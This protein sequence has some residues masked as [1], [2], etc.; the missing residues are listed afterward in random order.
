MD[1]TIDLVGSLSDYTKYILPA[2]QCHDFSLN[3]SRQIDVSRS[4]TLAL[5]TTIRGLLQLSRTSASKDGS[6]V[7]KSRYSRVA[8][9]SWKFLGTVRK[10]R[11]LAFSLGRVRSSANSMIDSTVDVVMPANIISSHVSFSLSNPYLSAARN[12]C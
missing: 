3:D 6:L 4:N 2:H 10:S 9:T 7:I 5:H 8:A 1:S 12:R 11:H